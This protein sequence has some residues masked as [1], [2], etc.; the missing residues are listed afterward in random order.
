MTPPMTPLMSPPMTPLRLAFMGAP[1]FALPSLRALADAGHEIFLV[2]GTVRDLLR[3]VPHDCDLDFAVP[4][5]PEKR[6]WFCCR[7]RAS[8]I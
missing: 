5:P 7:I 3:G 4:T 2:G 8:A 1:D 6:L